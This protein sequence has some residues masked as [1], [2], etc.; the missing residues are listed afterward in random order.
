MTTDTG[1]PQRL[2]ALC[3]LAEAACEQHRRQE[4]SRAGYPGIS[5]ALLP[6]L[7]RLAQQDSTISA[8]A[9]A[10]QT[11]V[12]DVAQRVGMLEARDYLRRLG[13]AGDIRNRIMGITPA[14]RAAGEASRQLDIDIEDRVIAQ[15]GAH[16]AHVARDVLKAVI[17]ATRPDRDEPAGDRNPRLRRVP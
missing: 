8:L 1:H 17:A 7:D 10:M 4:L 16:D 2:I 13:A 3:R 11:T 12:Q 9:I 6:I 5:S 15:L 14:G